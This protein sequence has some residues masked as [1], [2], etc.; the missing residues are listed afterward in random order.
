MRKEPVSEFYDYFWMMDEEVGL[1]LEKEIE[2]EYA[3]LEDFEDFLNE[4]IEPQVWSYDWNIDAP[5]FVPNWC[6]LCVNGA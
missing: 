5:I 2:A 6:A 4:S 3:I 1:T